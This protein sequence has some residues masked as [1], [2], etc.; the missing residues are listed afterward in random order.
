MTLPAKFRVNKP[1]A[2]G[3]AAPAALP[4]FAV[5]GGGGDVPA[6]APPAL[7]IF[8]WW[9][10]PPQGSQY[11]YIDTGNQL[12]AAGA[13]NF[14][15]PNS[16][17][18]VNAAEQAVIVGVSLVVQTPTQADDFYYTML[19]NGGPVSGL[20]RLRNFPITANAAVRDF[21][22]YTIRLKAGD[23]ISWTVSNAGAAVTVGVS[24]LGWRTNQSDIARLDQGANY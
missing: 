11:I 4:S 16:G 22:G 21:N 24:Y 8:P 20:D 1:A 3:G 23:R 14:L 9:Y 13:Q 7:Q 12:V 18:Q 17:L 15:L 5:G 2:P 6:V 19:R 10:Y